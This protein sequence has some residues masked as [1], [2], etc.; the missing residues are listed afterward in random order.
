[1]GDII[2]HKRTKQIQFD[3]FIKI[4]QAT[5]NEFIKNKNRTSILDDKQ[6]KKIFICDQIKI[7]T[8]RGKG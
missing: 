3:L 1:M 8:L 5:E 7:M 6:K 4:L 2:S